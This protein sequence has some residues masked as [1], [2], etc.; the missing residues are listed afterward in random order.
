[1]LPYNTK[2]LLTS[3]SI[4]SHRNISFPSPIDAN[5]KLANELI[6]PGAIALPPWEDLKVGDEEEFLKVLV[7]DI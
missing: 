3:T 2:I 1:M 5:S 6:S 7:P 4:E